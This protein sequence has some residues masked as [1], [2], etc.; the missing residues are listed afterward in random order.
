MV[1]GGD[2]LGVD[3]C[4]WDDV[5]GTSW[6]VEYDPG[7]GVPDRGGGGRGG[8][9][10]SGGDEYGGTH[11]PVEDVYP[12]FDLL[13]AGCT[14]RLGGGSDPWRRNGLWDNG[15]RGDGQHLGLPGD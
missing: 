7:V 6:A 5:P 11:W 15:G 4:A 13:G 3:A 12:F 1:L 10:G 2:L 9:G 14:R 8:G